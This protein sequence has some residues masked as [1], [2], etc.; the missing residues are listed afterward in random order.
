[1]ELLILGLKH[2]LALLPVE[3]HKFPRFLRVGEGLFFHYAVGIPAR[4]LDDLAGAVNGQSEVDG[5]L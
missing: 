2:G 1:V 5:G 4:H 3:G